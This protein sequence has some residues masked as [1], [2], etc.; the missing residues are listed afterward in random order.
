MTWY[1]AHGV[2]KRGVVHVALVS[3]RGAAG[4]RGMERILMPT[5]APGVSIVLPCYNAAPYL[6]ECLDSVVGQTLAEIQIICINDGSTDNTLEILREYAGRDARVMIIDKPNTGYGHSMNTGIDAALGEYIGIVESDDYILPGMYEALYRTASANR[7]DFVKSDFYRFYGE[8]NTREIV[9]SDLSVLGR[10]YGRQLNPSENPRLMDLYLLNQTGIFSL[11]F[12]VKNGIRF[13][14][15]PGA[16]FQDNGFWFQTFCLAK[17]AWFMHN[18]WYML[19]RDNPNS[20]VKSREKVFCICDEYDYIRAFLDRDPDRAEKFMPMY[21]KSKY[22]NYYFAFQRIGNEFK[23]LFLRR[24]SVEFYQARAAG[25]LRQELFTEKKWDIL[26]RIIDEPETFHAGAVDAAGGEYV[27][28]L[29]QRLERTQKDLD[30]IRKS[31]AY[32]FLQAAAVVPRLFS[33]AV[34]SWRRY[35][36]R[37]ALKRLFKRGKPVSD[38]KVE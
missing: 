28:L 3:G 11:D 27:A 8:G 30:R 12:L 32:R 7:L 23:M 1:N 10:I 24:M 34:H 21:Q 36:T 29:E 38:N 20:S 26:N 18:A 19:R 13:N 35:G 33:K 31:Y 14:E 15:T 16:S 5:A 9:R 37:Y 2:I 6:R 4:D 22:E 25:Q 17:R